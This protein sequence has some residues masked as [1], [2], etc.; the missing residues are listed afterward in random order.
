MFGYTQEEAVG[1]S[2]QMIMPESYRIQHQRHLDA[3]SV[4]PDGP[5]KY[6]KIYEVSITAAHSC[7]MV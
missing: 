6:A 7:S 3:A 4:S 1:K 5:K 2:L